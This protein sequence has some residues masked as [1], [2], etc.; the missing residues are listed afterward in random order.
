VYQLLIFLW[1]AAKQLGTPVTLQEIP[2]SGVIT[3]LC[4]RKAL[5][6]EAGART[7]PTSSGSSGII[8]PTAEASMLESQRLTTAMVVNLNKSSEAYVRQITKDESTKSALSRLA[9]DQA[10]LFH[11]LTAENF[12]TDGTPELNSFTAITESR[13]PMRSINMVR[14]E[15][16]RWG[17]SICDKSLLQFLSSG[18]LAPDM[19]QEPDGLTSLG[20]V[21]HHERHKFEDKNNVATENMQAM[22]GENTFDEDSIKRYTKKQFFV[23]SRIEDWSIQLFSTAKFLDLLTCEDGIA[24]E[25]Y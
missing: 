1:A 18:Y 8:G 3:S 10:A 14:Q 25:A 11:L 4:D 12:E 13:D 23:P 20:F 21:P 17:G 5:A 6:L 19:N 22:F 7:G 15:T 2:E 16:R 24:A 9:P